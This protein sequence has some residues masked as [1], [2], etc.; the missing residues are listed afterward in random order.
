M[1]RELWAGLRVGLPWHHLTPKASSGKP[2]QAPCLE[3]KTGLTQGVLLCR[4]V[5]FPMKSPLHPVPHCR[6]EVVQFRH[7]PILGAMTDAYDEIVA[8]DVSPLLVLAG[9]GAG[10]T[11][12]LADRVTRLVTASPDACKRTTVLTFGKD[13]SEHMRSTLLDQERHFKLQM[14][15]LPEIST[16]HSL[17]LSIV[18]TKPRTVGLRK[19]D[20]Q[21]QAD[22]RVK[23]LLYRD[24]ALLTG[25]TEEEGNRA[26]ECKG[27]GEC[28][29]D[30]PL[31]HICA[32][33]WEV[34]SKLNRL[35]FDDQIL[36]AIRI[37]EEKPDVLAACQAKCANLLV[38]EYQ[39]I[40]AA[41]ARLIDLLS[42][43]SRSGL[44]AVG[45]DAQSIYAFRG[46]SPEFIL[47]FSRMYDGAATP[48]LLHSRRCPPEILEPA[49]N[50]LEC[51]YQDWSGPFDLEYHTESG[52]PPHVWQVP[53]EIAEA[54]AVA[55]LARQYV[56]ERK[57]VLVLAPKAD[58][59]RLISGRLR[60][61][62]VAHECPTSLLPRNS[63]E[64]LESATCVSE[65]VA[66]PTDSF[67]ARLAIEEIIN[68]D[69]SARIPCASKRP[70]CSKKSIEQ[71]IHE[72]ARVASLW[73]FVDRETS[74]YD[75]LQAASDEGVLGPLKAVC[76]RLLEAYRINSTD[77]T[78]G[79]F[80]KLLARATG[81]WVQPDRFGR[82]LCAAV[83]LLRPV[84]AAGTGFAQLMTMRKAKGL[85]AD[86]VI[87]VG[88]EDDVIP[89]PSRD[90]AE[91]ARLFYVSMT[92]AK[93][94]LYLLHAF[95]R[96]RSISFGEAITHKMRSR[97]LDALGIASTYVRT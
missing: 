21:V 53:S 62:N 18:K 50:V 91:E 80:A 87:V 82:D 24:S 49:T 61:W 16:M 72:E 4:I 46:A 51:Y 2:S 13:A 84:S 66:N 14:E 45:D 11:F 96:P 54:E 8:H 97:F 76:R 6:C 95:R 15:A 68:H 37:L 94:H 38:D 81:G 7:T 55:R 41:Q 17:G 67:L 3:P 60:R 64:R 57:T 59:F 58:F 33:Y 19:T 93:K 44:F 69:F 42:S 89:S 77:D 83:R 73:E 79:E 90:L 70:P 56:N 26:L 75:A 20:L 85:E 48:P 71:R 10:K 52:E 32:K 23:R 25:S 63:L 1:L 36:L 9:P 27:R 28:T 43:E 35:D 12:L 65:W 86:V 31:C 39:D 92:R 22:E 40:N 47:G 30:G 5:G 74:L 88:L 29:R 78:A 34:M